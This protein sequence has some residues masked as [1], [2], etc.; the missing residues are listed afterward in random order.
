MEALI[1]GI[2]N[3]FTWDIGMFAHL[4]TL[5]Y[6]LGFLFKNQLTLRILVLIATICYIIYYYAFPAEPLWGAIMGSVLIMIANIIGT[7]RLLYDR[8]PMKV[9][10]TYREMHEQ[11]AGVKPGEFRRLLKAGE[12]QTA[13]TPIIL[14]KQNERAPFLYYLIQGTANAIKNDNEFSI[15][16]G[17]FVGEVSFIL[18]SQASATVTVPT[19]G[20]FMRWEQSKLDKLL[21][22]NPNLRHAFE[23]Q[24][25]RDMAEKV[26]GSQP[27]YTKE[28]M[29]V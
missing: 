12:V 1:E 28:L 17:R 9:D 5:G 19:G 25:G 3:S 26:A 2:S 21:K 18:N 6:V 29:V 13:A 27:V 24:I 20:Q 10:M 11:L 22:K 14:T 7:L 4:A 8:F 15:P 16:S 23:A